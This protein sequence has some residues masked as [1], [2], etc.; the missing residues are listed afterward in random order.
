[1]ALM[2]RF[3]TRESNGLEQCI[4]RKE[5]SANLLSEEGS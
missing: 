1:M 2:K 4:E 5:L 3:N